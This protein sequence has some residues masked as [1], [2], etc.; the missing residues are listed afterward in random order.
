MLPTPVPVVQL[1]V[2]PEVRMPPGDD[3]TAAAHRS[4]GRLRG[5]KASHLAGE[6]NA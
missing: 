1:R 2:S 6:M 5:T 3:P 4:E